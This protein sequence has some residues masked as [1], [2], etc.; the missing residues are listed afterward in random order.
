MS[1]NQIVK[2]PSEQS[3]FDKSGQKN[4]VDFVLPGGQ[5]Q[6]YDLSRSYIAITVEATSSTSTAGDVFLSKNMLN[7][8]PAIDGVAMQETSVIHVPT[9]ATLIQ[10]AHISSQN[11]GKISDIRLVNKY[12]FTKSY[13]QRTTEDQR[14]DLGKLNPRQCEN[15]TIC[16]VSNEFNTFG[17]ENSRIRTHD[18]RIPLKDVLPYCRTSAHDGNKHGATR[19]HTE[20]LFDQLKNQEVSLSAQLKAPRTTGHTGSDDDR[21]GKININAMSSLT[22]Q[23]A[24]VNQNR[25]ITTAA[26][27]GS[28][29]FLPFFVGQRLLINGEYNPNT[30]SGLANIPEMERT[31]VEIKQRTNNDLVDLVLNADLTAAVPVVNNGIF[32]NLVVKDKTADSTKG[33]LD[34][35]NCE[36][37]T[38]IVQDPPKSSVVTYDTILSEEDTYSAGNSLNKVYDIPMMTKNVYIM[39]FKGNGIASDDQHLETYR[40]AIDNVEQSQGLVTVGSAE[41]KDNIMRVFANGGGQLNNISELYFTSQGLSGTARSRGFRS[42]MIAYPVPFLNR[43]QKLQVEMNA[44]AGQNL[45]GRLVVYYDVVRQV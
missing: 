4:N 37:V 45:T 11:K 25:T 26:K 34:I 16:G 5:G 7:L 14:N 42:T 21:Q 29:N 13:Y 22:T 20:I 32:S 3:A 10:N 12:A 35:L 24:V 39:F 41:H 44:T 38:E 1:L 31:I 8:Q 36:L 17:K 40:L 43:S 27:Y 2:I 23:D 33:T 9:S 15:A 6:V 30:G 28:K 19:L 18:I